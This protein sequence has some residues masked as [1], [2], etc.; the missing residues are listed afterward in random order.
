MISNSW[1]RTYKTVNELGTGKYLCVYS[2]KGISTN[3]GKKKKSASQIKQEK[4]MTAVWVI[5]FI[6]GPLF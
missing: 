4:E 6:R 3:H 1:K 2:S 5:L